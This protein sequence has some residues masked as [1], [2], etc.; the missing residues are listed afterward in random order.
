MDKTLTHKIRSKFPFGAAILL[1]AVVVVFFIFNLITQGS[2]LTLTN[3]KSIISHAVYPALLAW[4]LS[5]VFPTGYC[6][7]SLGSNLILSAMVGAVLAVDLNLGYFGLFAGAIVCGLGLTMFGMFTATT[8]KIPSWINGLG[9]AMLYETATGLIV[10][11]RTASGLGIQPPAL[12]SSMREIGTMPYITIFW[13]VGAVVAYFLLNK[14]N[15]GMG[16]RALGSNIQVAEAM[17]LKYK[18]ALF[19]SGI[20]A[21]LFL[22]VAAAVYMSY[23]GTIQSV[24]GLSSVSQIFEPMAILMLATAINKYINV[25][26]GIIISSFF[27]MGF[28]NFLTHIGV[29]SGTGQEICLGLVVVFFGVLSQ[30]NTKEVV[31]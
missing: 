8:F 22:G 4:S 29:P 28:F 23:S 21:G 9:L 20:V 31:K 14:T 15:I 25:S 27:V 1:L 6:D 3:I 18:K 10:D 12:T 5:F 11:I 30:R 17:G 16:S 2:F 26:I 13:V 7:L 24:S 19:H